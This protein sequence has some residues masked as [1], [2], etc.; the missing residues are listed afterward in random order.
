MLGRVPSNAPRSITGRPAVPDF[1]ASPYGGDDCVAMLTHGGGVG[2]RWLLEAQ[3][4][5]PRISS[6]CAKH[7]IDYRVA[8]ASP[9]S[10]PFPQGRRSLFDNTI[11][12]GPA[13]RN[14][15]RQPASLFSCETFPLGV[16]DL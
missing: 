3:P 7:V 8:V 11:Q 6:L 16:G 1:G 4:D 9:A 2:G 10:R 12:H 14:Q 15:R 13:C 5:H